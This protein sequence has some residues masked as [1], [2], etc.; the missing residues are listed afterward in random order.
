MTTYGIV[1]PPIFNGSH[2]TAFFTTKAS[3]CDKDAVSKIAGIAANNIYLP[4]QKHTDK[5]LAVDYELEPKIADAVITDRKGI[6]IGVQTADC[7]PVLLYDAKRRIAGAVHAGW[8]G[9]AAGI[10][11]N[12]IQAMTDRFYSS[13]DDILIAVG[14]G[15]RWCCYNVGYEVVEAVEKVTSSELGV[16][17]SKDYIIKKGEKYCLDL[18]TANKYQALS[19]GVPADNVWMSEECTSCLPEKYYSYRHM[20]GVTGRQ[21]GF[22][23]IV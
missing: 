12:T 20:K 8:R 15:I 23:G 16:K 1:I 14:T 19:S 13:P 9:T 11:K 22:I 7:V 4:V 5:V 21:C 10:L 3:G 6:L 18:P 17:R 2:V